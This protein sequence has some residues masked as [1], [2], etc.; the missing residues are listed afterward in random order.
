MSKGEIVYL[1]YQKDFV[2]KDGDRYFIYE[3]SIFSEVTSDY[4]VN[5]EA[6]I[7]T[8]D[9][10]LISSSLY[11]KHGKL[12]NNVID[13]T[14]LSRLVAGKKD[15]SGDTKSWDIS[16]TIKPLYADQH[17]FDQYMSMYYRRM[18]L[19]VDSYM[20]FAHKLA[21]YADLI[22]DRAHEVGELNRFY[23]L[24]VPLYNILSKVACRGI[25]IS[26]DILKTHKANIKYD[27]Y[28]E[29][30]KFAEKHNV[31]YEEPSE[32]GI[33]DKLRLLGYHV[34]NYEIDFLI[35]FL[36]SI[37]GYTYDLRKLQKLNK[38]YRV[39]NSISSEEKKLRPITDTHATSTSRIYFKSPNIQNISK[40]YRN[41][42]ISEDNFKLSYIDYD[43]FEV[44]IMAALSGD[45]TMKN[46]YT[47]MDAYI[48][49][50]K[51]IFG[52]D[53]YRKESK[54]LFLSYTY[55]MSMKNILSSVRQQMGDVES[56]KSYFAGFN[57]FEQ[58]KEKIFEEFEKESRISSLC[59]NYLNRT[60]KGK[61]TN[62]EKR[63][64]VSQVVQGTGSYIFKSALL[65]LSKQEGVEI[66]IPMHDAV[67]I[68]H[69]ST[70]DP[71]EAVNIFENTMTNI[72][73][74]NI[75]GKASIEDFYQTP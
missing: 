2:E 21:E 27:Y 22:F 69:L 31:F 67:L 34:E 52:N 20:L 35:D 72:L 48:D 4:V 5:L 60:Q 26:N 7:V 45:S 32:A 1:L 42:F 62:K 54:I 9:Y 18:V 23:D 70:Y 68:Q 58:W 47:N 33:K 57:T 15:N 30:K 12:P 61:L 16:N 38:S 10:W 56:A 36:P 73:K 59:G 14:L 11:K 53:N 25:C 44:G 13:I 29:L 65:E 40:K 66:L 74:N 39:F 37:D 41:I 51:K 19:N 49:L 8:H 17:D 46:F 43:Q 28:R 64:A 50:S 24:E 6:F 71:A 55:G 3:G 75:K 63:S